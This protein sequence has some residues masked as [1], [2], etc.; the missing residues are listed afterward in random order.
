M[1]IEQ[2]AVNRPGSLVPIPDGHTAFVPR[3]LP[4]A[5]SCETEITQANDAAMLALG[6]LR[7]IIPFMPNPHLLTYPF[8][9]REAIL[10]SKIEGTHT[11]AEQLY[12]FEVDSPPPARQGD[13]LDVRDAR[14]VHN[15][16]RALETG[17]DTLRKDFPICNRL[18][19]DLHEV[20]LDGVASENGVYTYPGKFRK[21]QAYIGSSDLANARFVPPPPEHIEKLMADLE[22]YIHSP[23]KYHPQLVRIAIIHYQFEA[24]HPFS[25]GNGRIGRLLISLLLASWNV[26]PEP[27]LYRSA[28]FEQHLDE[29]RN[30]LWQVSCNCDWTG[31]VEFFLEGVVTEARDAAERA[32]RVLKLREEYRQ[33]LQTRKGSNTPLA[34]VDFLFRSPFVTTRIAADV[35]EVTYNSGKKAV[36]KLVEAG[37]LFEHHKRDWNKI[38]YSKPILEILK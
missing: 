3:T 33:L 9:R 25:D 12:L 32:R 14:E 34:L 35:C 7:A 28:F 29:Y 1:D 24:I 26:L 8:L 37:I 21:T 10:S 18:L 11:E 20:L 15:Y 27:L 23:T 30:R 31:W 38:Y 16:V 13:S 5:F 17:L 2:F 19:C 6:E 36:E 4:P 22:A